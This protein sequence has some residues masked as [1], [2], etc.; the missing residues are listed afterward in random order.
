MSEYHYIQSEPGL[1]TVGIG[2]PGKGGDWEPES[3]HETPEAAAERVR[4]LNGEY[5]TS[6]DAVHIGAL[7]K[8]N[9]ALRAFAQK[10]LDNFKDCD[11]CGGKGQLE[12]KA[13]GI[14]FECRQC[15]GVGKQI[16]SRGVLLVEL[17]DEARQL[18]RGTS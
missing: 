15:Q 13:Y 3:D 17:P 4:Y 2:R 12:D 16:D 7:E 11:Y 10:F 9:A 5:G 8:E 18:L 14:S 1:W 6:K